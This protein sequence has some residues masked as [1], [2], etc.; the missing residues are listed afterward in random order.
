METVV[1][2]MYWELFEESKENKDGKESKNIKCVLCPNF[3][4]IKDGSVGACG[5]RKNVNG[6]LFAETYGLISS[7]ALDPIEKKPLYHFCSGMKI[8]SIGSIGCNFHCPFCQNYTISREYENVPLQR[9]TAE[10]ISEMAVKSVA[11]GNA[12]VAYTYNEPF[13]NFEFVLDCCRLVKSSGLVN[14]LVT[15]GYINEE[16]LRDMLPYIDA[17]NIDIKGDNKGTYNIVGGTQDAVKNVIEISHKSCRIELTTLAV[18]EVKVETVEKIAKWI[19]ELD[20]RIPYH[21]SRFFPRYKYI[22]QQPTPIEKMYELKQAAEV[23][24]NNVYLGNV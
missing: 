24:L 14:V 4:I 21:I 23:Y 16:P 10:E 20:K 3:C 2:A 18:P 12:G 9:V 1:N 5:V 11:D 15:N 19:A 7:I 6:S 13:I 22:Q 17:M 8:L